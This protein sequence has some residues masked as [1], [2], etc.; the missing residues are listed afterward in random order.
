M[1]YSELSLKLYCRRKYSGISYPK[2][3][4]LKKRLIKLVN[5]KDWE[6]ISSLYMCIKHFEE[7][8]YKKGKNS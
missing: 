1:L 5:R 4:D 7:K 2:E 6:L 3:E 8:Y